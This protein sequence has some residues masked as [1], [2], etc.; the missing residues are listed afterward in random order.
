MDNLFF[1]KL[2]SDAKPIS[3]DTSLFAA[4]DTSSLV[5]S[6]SSILTKSV[7][8]EAQTPKSK[9]EY[10][11]VQQGN[12]ELYFSVFILDLILF[13]VILGLYRKFFFSSLHSLFSIKAYQQIESKKSIIQHPSMIILFSIF[14]LNF[15]IL[16][17][18]Y[19]S[20]YFIANRDIIFY[21]VVLGLIGFYLLKI[22]TIFLS[23]QIFNMR[24]SGR[25]Y[26]DY[27]LISMANIALFL[28]VFLWLDIY[29]GIGFI[30]EITFGFIALFS[31]I[32][33]IRTYA[34]IMPKSVFSPFHFFLYLCTV[35]ILPLLVLGKI[36]MQGIM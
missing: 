20:T 2:Y 24:N 5:V 31:L 33:V 27:I 29:S 14:I 18:A 28:S 23:A 1:Y 25:I 19:A 36:V 22:I 34:L 10:I 4:F 32:R 8:Y 9:L 7:F 21:D 17:Q 12:N 13:I 3:G 15:S 26:I 11:P 35:E 16:L 6:N 30:F